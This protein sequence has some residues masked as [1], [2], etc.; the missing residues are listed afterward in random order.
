MNSI[1]KLTSPLPC[2]V[3]G[4]NMGN[5]GLELGSIWSEVEEHCRHANLG[6]WGLLGE[7][8]VLF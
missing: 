7:R 8:L 3:R 6:L 2:W 1:C 4:G 5:L